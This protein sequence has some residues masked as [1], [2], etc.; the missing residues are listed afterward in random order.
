MKRSIKQIWLIILVSLILTMFPCFAKENTTFSDVQK[1]EWYSESVEYVFENGLMNGTSKTT[2]EP[3]SSITRGMIVTIIY[4]MEGMPTVVSESK[5]TDVNKEFYYYSPIVW[6]TENGIVNGYSKEIFAP[7]DRITREQFAAILYRYSD[8]KELDVSFD[9]KIVEELKKYDDNNLINDYA[10]D[11]I[12]WANHSKLITGTSATTLE[13][14]GPATR[15][16]AATI[17]MRFDKWIDEAESE[18]SVEQETGESSK[19][20]EESDKSESKDV[21][22]DNSQKESIKENEKPSHINNTDKETDN[23]TSDE[24][25]EPDDTTDNKDTDDYQGLYLK[26]N[27]SESISGNNVEVN[28]SLE[29]NPGIMVMVISFEYDENAMKLVKV[30]NG[31]VFT[32][33]NGY[34][35]T[36]PRN[37]ASECRALWY[38]L[39]DECTI[40]SGTVV[41]LVFEVFD[42]T[43]KGSYPVTIRY[44]SDDVIDM[45]EENLALEIINGQIIVE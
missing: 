14:Q 2:F 25:K 37:M 27:D 15:A 41:T 35:F 38:T 26:V 45:N 12:S 33:K 39:E 3:A 4:R 10:K 8:Y 1:N 11:A 22:A 40:A 19:D 7:D 34:V 17:F 28:V 42:S 29:N 23:V 32:N 16:Q 6:A 9:L 36:S 5:Y 18:N 43:Q 21:S 44:N 31:D 13:P 24:E 20:T 30:L